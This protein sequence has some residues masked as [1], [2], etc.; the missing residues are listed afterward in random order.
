MS[1]TQIQSRMPQPKQTVMEAARGRGSAKVQMSR[2]TK[3]LSFLWMASNGAEGQS[4]P[5]ESCATLPH[6]HVAGI[7]IYIY[8]GF[9]CP[10]PW[11][12]CFRIRRPERSLCVCV[13]VCFFSV[14]CKCFGILLCQT[15]GNL[16][17][18]LAISDSTLVP[19]K[20]HGI[21]SFVICCQSS[22]SV[23]IF[24]TLPGQFLLRP[25]GGEIVGGV[26][27]SGS[28]RCEWVD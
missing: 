14:P 26:A 12:V 16:T 22:E 18:F 5:P 4:H 17:P 13:C 25:R 15:N 9:F 2:T 7:Y 27:P 28:Q 11:P 21:F 23:I 19:L 1:A 20:I 6:P 8:R 10:P 3:Q 24:L